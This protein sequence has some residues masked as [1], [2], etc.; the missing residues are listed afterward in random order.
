M[1]FKSKQNGFTLI[2]VSIVIVIIGILIAAF[3]P[4]YNIYQ[5]ELAERQTVNNI[6]NA[7]NLVEDFVNTF[8]RY[9]CPASLNASQDDIDYGMEIVNECRARLGDEALIA[10]N[11]GDCSM[12]RLNSDGYCFTRMID[13]VSGLPRATVMLG[14]LPFRQLGLR[15]EP[16]A[17]ES[18]DGY[19][20]KL[21][22]AVSFPLTN[23]ATFDFDDTGIEIIDGNGSSLLEAPGT[24]HYVIYSMGSN[25][26][27]AFSRYGISTACPL[28]NTDTANCNV[29]DATF[30]QQDYESDYASG[31]VYDDILS[32]STGVRENRWM[33]AGDDLIL[34]P[35]ASEASVG[36]RAP[37]GYD[38]QRTVDVIGDVR[39]TGEIRLNNI[40][41]LSNPG[42]CFNIA[43]L[44]SPTGTIRCSDPAAP[45][46]SEISGGSATCSAGEVRCPINTYMTGINAD[47]TL[48]CESFTT[49]NCTSETVTLCGDAN[50]FPTSAEGT[51]EIALGGISREQRFRCQA[52]SWTSIG[53]SGVCSCAH[54]DG[55]T[56]PE[57]VPCPTGYS[58]DRTRTRTYQC[59]PG[60]WGSFGPYD[61]STCECAAGVEQ[62]QNRSCSQAHSD[63]IIPH[64]GHLPN[65]DSVRIKRTSV[66]SSGPS[67][68]RSWDPPGSSSWHNRSAWELV[69]N[70]CECIP[71]VVTEDRPCP[72]GFVDS[73]DGDPNG[74]T[75]QQTTTCDSG[76]TGPVTVSGWVEIADRCDCDTTRAPITRNESCPTGFVGHKEQQALW[77]CPGGTWGPWT[78]IPGRDF[79]VPAVEPVCSW[80][81][82]GTSSPAVGIPL[83][84]PIG[85]PG[86][87]TC[88]ETGGDCTNGSYNYNECRC[89]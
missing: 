78:D 58:G 15:D 10:E 34:I 21:I 11:I 71:G 16:G 1:L 85:V 26:F 89:E 68:A 24:G 54:P 25:E 76:P 86:S 39:S 5:R 19:G 8:D 23:Q 7:Q 65:P 41:S 52:G 4:V 64:A 22:Y 73:L 29:V 44:T 69:S 70:G 37:P 67:G 83:G 72:V 2:E 42:A 30:L 63:G 6:A 28:T 17:Y 31:A 38:P 32:F 56:E 43:T 53:A 47:G 79:C 61:M 40:C 20:N 18:V 80:Q 35:T 50:F 82:G 27:G 3:S 51:E 62:F 14:A 75:V 87:C 46:I 9:P 13:P 59:P 74:I 36:I 33:E 88:G 81:A 77:Q 12:T 48:R 84:S 45:F 60:E 57:T 66:C 55:H 49:A